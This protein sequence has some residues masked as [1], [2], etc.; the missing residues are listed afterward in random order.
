MRTG[1][2]MHMLVREIETGGP[3]SLISKEPGN[4]SPSR[5]AARQKPGSICKLSQFL[6][7]QSSTDYSISYVSNSKIVFNFYEPISKVTSHRLYCSAW[8]LCFSLIRAALG[9]T[10]PRV[11]IREYGAGPVKFT[12]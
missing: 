11:A 6:R 4:F 9:L 10:S 3:V 5:C 7:S 8:P 12:T 1:L 2:V